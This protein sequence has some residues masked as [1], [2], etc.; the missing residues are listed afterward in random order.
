MRKALRAVETLPDSG[1][2]RRF[3]AGDDKP[4]ALAD[5]WRQRASPDDAGIGCKLGPGHPA[6]LFELMDQ[7][8]NVLNLQVADILMAAYGDRL[9]PRPGPG[10]GA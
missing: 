2:A 4:L 1:I 8:G 5:T 6:G 3:R 9:Y 7:T 10:L